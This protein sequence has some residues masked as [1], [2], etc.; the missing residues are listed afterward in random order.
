M[1]ESS[2]QL[3]DKKEMTTTADLERVEAVLVAADVLVR[4]VQPG[5]AASH[6]VGIAQHPF[7]AVAAPV[8]VAQGFGLKRRSSSSSGFTC[9][10]YRSAVVVIRLHMV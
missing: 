5:P 4:N 7:A 10:K 6:Q 9:S 8:V 1:D 3:T 2:I